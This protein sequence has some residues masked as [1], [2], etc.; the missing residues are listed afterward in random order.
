VTITNGVLKTTPLDKGTP[1]EAEALAARLH[2]MLPRVRITDLLTEVAGWTGFLDCF[3]HLRTGETPADSR[4]LMAGLLADGLNLGLTR[5][6]EASN[7]ASL[8]QLAWTA[9]WHIRDE[10][11]G[12]ALRCLVDQQQREPFAAVFGKGEASSSD[13]QFF[14]AAGLGRAAGRLNPHYGQRPGFKVYTH[15]SDRYGA[16]HTRLIAA[17]ASEALHV[18]DALLCHESEVTTRRHHTDGGGDSV[19]WTISASEAVGMI[20]LDRSSVCMEVCHGPGQAIRH[21]RRTVLR[22]SAGRDRHRCAGRGRLPRASRRAWLLAQHRYQLRLRPGPPLA[23]PGL[24]GARLG[25]TDAGARGR[26]VG[27]STRHA[28]A[29]SGT[30]AYACVGHP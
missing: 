27:P 10:T 7:I 26:P 20:A 16:F 24:R 2:A 3:T 28:G 29:A 8:G 19:M 22:R 18:L 14:Q 12:L 5:M 13:G 21:H 30:A 9:D 23:L 6:A 1:P 15:L 4:V 17:T 11:Y 25:G